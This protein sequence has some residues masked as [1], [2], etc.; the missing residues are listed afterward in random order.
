MKKIINNREFKRYFFMVISSFLYAL[1]LSQFFAPN[2]IVAGG[3]S[4]LAIVLNY[5]MPFIT[6]GTFN[7]LVNVPVLLLGFKV[8]G[9]KFILRC[10]LTI[11]LISIFTD[12][13]GVIT[14]ITD[15][16]ILATLYGGILQGISIGMFCKYSVSSGGTELLGR[17]IYKK[18]KSFPITYFIY[19]LDALVVLISVIVFKQ[20]E[21]IRS[22]LKDN[23]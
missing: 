3:L 1:S 17:V 5:L 10:L 13:T 8:E 20:P 21:N 15:D 2:N 19:A 9:W 23:K 22:S 12:I 7:L 4:G 18:L 6:V 11:G 16:K 14:P